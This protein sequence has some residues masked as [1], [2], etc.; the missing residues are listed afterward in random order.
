MS[1]VAS[2]GIFGH[3]VFYNVTA[4]VPGSTIVVLGF[5]D[6]DAAV[7][8]LVNSIRREGL[9]FLFYFILFYFILVFYFWVPLYAMT[10]FQKSLKSNS[11]IFTRY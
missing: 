4:V 5:L 10:V 3:S 1:E 2:L 11:N 9:L 6:L 8:S 7:C